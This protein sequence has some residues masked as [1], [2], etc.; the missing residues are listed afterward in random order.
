MTRKS[1]S[2]LNCSWAQAAEAIGDKWSILIVRDAFFGVR[3]FS[4]FEASLGISNNIHSQRLEH[5]VAH[6]ILRKQL[7]GLGSTR[8]EYRLTEKGDALLPVIIALAQWSDE[9]V[10]GE[11]KEPYKVMERASNKPIKRIAIENADG[12]E[13]EFADLMLTAG[14]GA[15]ANNK[16][17]VELM[18]AQ[19]SSD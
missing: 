12:E 5:L 10:F 15:N 7:I 3:T 4:A 8:Y 1:L 6:E 9:R 17:L 2:H 13:M 14:P 19:S 11:G 18:A 16:R